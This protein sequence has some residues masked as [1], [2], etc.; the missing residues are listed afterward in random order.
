MLADEERGP[1]GLALAGWGFSAVVAFL[2][3]AAAWQ[4]GDAGQAGTR[5]RLPDAGS[6]EITGSIDGNGKIGVYGAPGGMKKPSA[7]ERLLTED[8]SALKRDLVALR[9]SESVAREANAA[10]TSRISELE[11]R[12]ASIG[13]NVEN[14]RTQLTAL[15]APMA[16]Q[17]L[18]PSR[19]TAE[20]DRKPLP[21]VVQS[22]PLDPNAPA[23]REL[24]SQRTPDETVAAAP[25]LKPDTTITGSIPKSARTEPAPTRQPQTAIRRVDRT[26][27]QATMPSPN[28]GSIARRNG[29]QPAKP[30]KLRIDEPLPPIDAE[31]KPAPGDRTAGKALPRAKPQTAAQ[32]QAAAQTVPAPS[33][34]AAP[35]TADAALSRSEFGIDLGGFATMAAL[36][37]HWDAFAAEHPDLRDALEPRAGISEKDGT[38]EVRLIAGPF[39]NAADAIVLCA[40]VGAKGAACQPALFSGQPVPMP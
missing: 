26:N 20:A 14:T 33:S 2:F 8:M 22:R 17:P 6:V 10:L 11:N 31:P 23:M 37:K 19:V 30:A 28:A 1:D 40:K 21:V 5:N 34:Q 15:A 39:I 35:G 3:A 13:Q 7:M 18:P 32:Q 9:R 16:G 25:D 29:E 38:L 12:I 27:E 4:F 24:A 36:R